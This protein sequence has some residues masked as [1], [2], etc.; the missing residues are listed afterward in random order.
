MIIPKKIFKFFIDR[1][2]MQ[3]ISLQ[4]FFNK[5]YDFIINYKN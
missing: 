2:N 3:K 5:M 1:K 4:Q